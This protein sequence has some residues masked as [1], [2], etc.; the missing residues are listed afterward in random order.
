LILALSIERFILAVTVESNLR[1]IPN[2][3]V[4]PPARM[5]GYQRN[6]LFN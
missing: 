2:I 1:T 4:S 6:Q 3:A 5:Y